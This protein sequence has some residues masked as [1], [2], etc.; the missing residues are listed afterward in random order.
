[1]TKKFF[2][3]NWVVTIGSGILAV[4]FLRLIDW[5][6]INDFFWRKIKNLFD[7]ILDFFG[8]PYSVKLYFLILIFITPLL[9]LYAYI[10]NKNISIVKHITLK[11]DSEPDWKTSY[12][13]DVFD[14][15]QYR[16]EY[17]FDHSKKNYLVTNVNPYCNDCTC[18]LVQGRCPNC[19]IDYTNSLWGGSQY[20][21]KNTWEVEALVIHRIE[22]KLYKNNGV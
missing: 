1:M 10:K 6:F 22:N 19:K 17:Q 15:V 13:K 16:W 9:L 18:L 12:T 3:N 2:S 20:T 7:T 4:L 14:G 5:L 8:T 21:I 11:V